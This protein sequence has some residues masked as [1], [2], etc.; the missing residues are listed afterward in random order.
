MEAKK[1]QSALTLTEMMVVI[2][3]VAMLTTLSLPAI[4]SFFKAMVLSSGTESM[5]SAAL[6]SARAIAAKEQRYAGIRFQNDL[7]RNQ[8][9]IFI[10][11]DP[12]MGAYFFRAVENLEPIK[13]PENIGLIDLNVRT[14]HRTSR[15]GAENPSARTLVANDLDDTNPANI[16][17]DG[18]NK[19]VTDAKTFSIAFSPSGK[20]LVH[21]VRTRNRD[22][23]Y[24][25]VN[26]SESMD[27]IFNSPINIINNNIGMFVQDDYAELGLGAE[28]GRTNFVI[29]EKD[30]FFNM[31]AIE[32]FNYVMNL[33][34][35]H[36]NPYT[37]TIINSR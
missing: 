31:S 32:K 17:P 5:I 28:F 3:T 30:K 36:I 20:L 15:F 23:D 1:R 12:N 27:D 8:Y 10:V 37:G 18:K 35:I 6:A 2:L 19:Y 26:P 24:Q 4:R 25:P 7:D 33:R 13:L 14:D 21:I 34:R 29:Y 22:G 9:A 16:G 11:Q